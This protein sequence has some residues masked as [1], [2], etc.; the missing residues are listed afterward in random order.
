ME[1]KQT[2]RVRHSKFTGL[3][4]R[5]GD[6]NAWSVPIVPRACNLLSR[7]AAQSLSGRPSIAFLVNLIRR[8]RTNMERCNA[9]PVLYV[10]KEKRLKKTAPYSLTPSVMI[11]VLVAFTPSHLS[12]TVF[13]VRN[14]VEMERTKR[15][16]NV[17]IMRTSVKSAQLH[18]QMSR[19]QRLLTSRRT[20]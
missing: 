20:S 11:N 12:S 1:L 16:W 10:L 9:K 17:R 5:E 4:H 2:S 19:P 13:L 6:T 8:I 7:A 15:R 3:D 18:A 14:A